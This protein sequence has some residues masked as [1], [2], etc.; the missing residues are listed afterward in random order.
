MQGS[1]AINRQEVIDQTAVA[2]NCHCPNA[3]SVGFEVTYSN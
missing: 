3:S 1:W 2:A